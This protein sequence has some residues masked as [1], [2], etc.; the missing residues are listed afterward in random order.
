MFPFS[1]PR[2]TPNIL[3]FKKLYQWFTCSVLIRLRADCF[4][5]R[6][7]GT[8][9]TSYYRTHFMGEFT[10]STTFEAFCLSYERV[11]WIVSHLSCFKRTRFR[12]YKVRYCWYDWSGNENAINKGTK[13]ESG[14]SYPVTLIFWPLCL[15]FYLLFL[16]FWLLSLASFMS[17]LL[18]SVFC[19]YFHLVFIVSNLLTSFLLSIDI[20]PC[21]WFLVSFILLF[22]SN[23]SSFVS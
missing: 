11:V 15:A 1:L 13:K 12:P 2:H 3:I 18:A 19:R 21:L 22:V 8:L 20:A 16:M 23:L 7:S 6:L 17:Y 9:S 10:E 5:G 14:A 4:N